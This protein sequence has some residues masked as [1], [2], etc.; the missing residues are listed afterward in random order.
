[1][2]ADI[3]R[4]LNLSCLLHQN[5][6]NWLPPVS[7]SCGFGN[8][9]LDQRIFPRRTLGGGKLFGGR[10]PDGPFRPIPRILTFHQINLPRSEVSP[11]LAGFQPHPFIPSSPGPEPVELRRVD[12]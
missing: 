6:D 1:M 9:W 4:S 10:H 7:H 2:E 5:S 12:R 8:R 3:S 11:V